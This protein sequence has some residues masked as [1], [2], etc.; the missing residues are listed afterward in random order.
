MLARVR[1][2]P[3]A[4][5]ALHSHP[6]RQVSYVAAGVFERRVL[7]SGDSFTIAPDVMHGVVARK[8]GVLINVF[9]PARE[10]FVS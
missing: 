2:A 8:P 1:S 4:A 5:G 10:E 3:G 6:H 9:S 7:R